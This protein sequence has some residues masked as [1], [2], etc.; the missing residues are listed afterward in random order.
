MRRAALQPAPRRWILPFP[1]PPSAEIAEE[2]THAEAVS[3]ETESGGWLYRVCED[4]NAM[5]LGHADTAVERLVL[6][7][8][9]DGHW[10]ARLSED[11]FADNAMLREAEIPASIGEIPET[12]FPN[13][14]S[15]EIRAYNGTAAMALAKKRG[16][17]FENRSEFDFFDDIVDLSEMKR[18]QWSLSGTTLTL[19][20]PYA[21]LAAEG[22]KLYL[23]A[24]DEYRSGLPV[25]LESV[26]LD[27]DGATA[28]VSA[29]N[30]MDAVN[31]YHVENEQLYVDYDNIVILSEG[32]ELDRDK[33]KSTARST[34]VVT[35]R[36]I[37]L[38]PFKINLEIAKGVTLSGS[39][40][41]TWDKATV[42]VDY[43]ARKLNSL[44]I[45][46]VDTY[47]CEL[48]L[49]SETMVEDETTWAEDRLA[50]KTS[51]E[52]RYTEKRAVKQMPK[53]NLPGRRKYIANVPLFSGAVVGVYASIYV[54]YSIEG[55]VTVGFEAKDTRTIN[56][57]NGKLSVSGPWPKLTD[58]YSISA[59][60][61]GKAGV[62]AD[63]DLR[64]G[65]SLGK[66]DVSV[67]IG[68][69]EIQLM[70]EVGCTAI[71]GTDFDPPCFDI[72]A[73][74]NL[75]GTARL[76]LVK[77]GWSKEFA[78][79]EIRD[80][81]Y[82][83]DGE[84]ISKPYTGYVEGEFMNYTMPLFDGKKLH[85]EGSEQK[86]TEFCFRNETPEYTA[87]FHYFYDG[88]SKKVTVVENDTFD[89]PEMSA[90]E[91]YEFVGWYTD[92]LFQN[93]WDSSEPATK[94]IELYA[95][96]KR[97]ADKQEDDP[98][99]G[100]KDPEDDPDDPDG[101]DD[102]APDNPDEEYTIMYSHSPDRVFEVLPDYGPLKSVSVTGV[103]GN[104]THITIPETVPILFHWVLN[105]TYAWRDVPVT[106]I[107]K[108]RFDDYVNGSI[109]SYYHQNLESIDL[110]EVTV[111]YEDAFSGLR[112]LKHVYS[113]QLDSLGQ[114]AFYNC[115]SLESITINGGY[116]GTKIGPEAFSG[117]T[118]LKSVT[119]LGKLNSVG[120]TAF[121]ECGNLESFNYNYKTST[122]EFD[123][124]VFYNCA[125]L[126]SFTFPESQTIIPGGMF[127]GCASLTEV[128]FP[129]GLKTI[130]ERAFSWSGII[131]ADLPD[132]ITSI[133]SWTFEHTEN[134]EYVHLP[135]SLERGSFDLRFE[136]SK[137]K[138][139]SIPSG[140]TDIGEYAFG[141]CK[142]LTRVELP[143]GIKSIGRY[144][145]GGC[146]SLEYINLPASLE[147]IADDGL[148]DCRSLKEIE[149]PAG[150]KRIGKSGIGMCESLTSI[151]LPD[152]L[153]EIAGNAF[154]YC[155]KLKS[156][157]IPD[158]AEV[159]GEISFDACD[160]LE[161][162]H[163][164]PSIEYY[165]VDV[166]DPS[167]QDDEYEYVNYY[168]PYGAGPEVKRYY[169]EVGDY[170][171]RRY[172][173][174]DRYMY[175]K[176]W[177][178]QRAFWANSLESVNLPDGIP[179]IPREA[180]QYTNLTTITIP[181]TVEEL[182]YRAFSGCE[183]L[184]SVSLPE[185]LKIV[186]QY[187][188][189]MCPSLEY[190]NIPESLEAVGQ[191]ACLLA[192]GDVVVP[193]NLKILEW[194]NFELRDLNS[195]TVWDSVTSI[196]SSAFYS[197][198]YNGYISYRFNESNP[199]ETVYVESMD[200]FV[201]QWFRENKPNAFLALI[202][203][204]NVQVSF[205]LKGG[206]GEVSSVSLP[207]GGRIDQP[208]D[209]THDQYDFLGWFSNR[210]CTE[211][212]DFD[213]RLTGNVTLY[214]GWG[215]IDSN[216][217]YVTDGGK[218]IVTNYKGKI[219]NLTMPDKLDGLTV[220]GLAEGAIPDF[221]QSL[222][223][224]STVTDVAPG[225]FRFAYSLSEIKLLG[226]NGRIRTNG[227][228][229][230][231]D[232]TLL[233]YPPRRAGSAYT[234]PNGTEEIAS[235]AMQ[236][237]SKLTQLTLPAS[238]KRID[239][240]A[241]CE[242]EQL[243]R[244]TFNADPESI[245]AGNFASHAGAP[246]LYGP[247]DAPTLVSYADANRLSYNIYL[248]GLMVD[249]ELVNVLP[250]RAGVRFD[251]PTLEE[252][253][254]RGFV[255]WTTDAEGENPWDGGEMP[256]HHLRLYAKWDNDFEYEITEDYGSIRYAKLTRY[257]G[258]K[259]ETRIPEYIDG[260]YV[261][262][263]DGDCFTGTSVKALIG[264]GGSN[265]ESFAKYHGLE[266][267]PI[268][269]TVHFDCAGG[270]PLDDVYLPALTSLTNRD[271]VPTPTREGWDFLMWSDE[272]DRD[273]LAYYLYVEDEDD[274]ITL[275]ARWQP[276]SYWDEELEDTVT[277]DTPPEIPFSFKAT[278][279]GLAITGYTGDDF[280]ATVPETIN[281]LPVVAIAAGAFEGSTALYSLTL[282]EG[283][284]RVG[285]RAF[286]DSRI[287]DVDM[288]G[289]ETIEAYAFYN[290]DSLT[291][292]G[293]PKVSEIGE[294][295]F[296][297]CDA[298]TRI[299]LPE[300]LEALD[301]G[302]FMDCDWL[303][304]IELP[305]ALERVE[306]SVFAEC[307]QLKRVTLGASVDEIADNAFNGC[308]ALAA[309]EVD[310]GNMYYS[311]SDGVLFNKAGNTLLRYPAGK[312]DASYTVPE[313]VTMIAAGAM[314]NSRLE[315][316]TLGSDVL[317][318]GAG[319]LQN[320]KA[321]KELN[322]NDG[323]EK[324]G[325]NAFSGC[326]ALKAVD[327]PD[328]VAV[329]RDSAFNPS[330][331]TEIS[332][333]GDTD[334]ADSALP[335]NGA[336]TVYGAKD[337]GAESVAEQRGIRFVDETTVQVTGISLPGKLT[338]EVGEVYALEAALTPADTTE[339]DI[340]W[341]TSDNAVVRVTDE[342]QITARSVGT[343]IVTAY[344]LNG[345]SAQCVVTVEP[346]AEPLSYEDID[347]SEADFR[348]PAFIDSIG[349]EAFMGIEAEFVFI[350]AGCRSIGERAFANCPNLR[351][352][353]F[354]D[355]DGV[356]AAKSFLEGSGRAVVYAKPGT[357]MANWK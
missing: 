259:T 171:Y 316:L 347:P 356:T 257:H 17:A 96:W 252:E 67:T 18:A 40:Q 321:L 178:A 92:L 344:A 35:G 319:T 209:P 234:V 320:S 293:M 59:A 8:S 199:D 126:K 337:S 290:R 165:Y 81:D 310:A 82:S 51:G 148:W 220:V 330:G 151:T 26:S 108:L 116:W 247:I 253:E 23:P 218:A 251:P 121:S 64:L 105:D 345:A 100:E 246:D 237:A 131:R 63:L 73:A 44:Q 338:L 351:V 296:A 276:I 354:E 169:K 84:D 130:E 184:F 331:L 46:L 159:Y 109:V 174:G 153:V 118:S 167:T 273:H 147:T 301:E 275:Y 7:K 270:V 135:A 76:G 142:Y 228:A 265:A 32:V 68:E 269:H 38:A 357:A 21:L 155:E 66:V 195:L 103:K 268:L 15:L 62:G 48:S 34:A 239:A 282:P 213:T 222:T 157:Y 243:S 120:F 191:G 238:L 349:D 298:L 158:N 274:E 101:P 308:A 29:I 107:T 39:V 187:V 117:C 152:G 196:A 22:K 77:T 156:L 307:K 272:P 306:G 311:S 281:G 288:P 203:A 79:K 20:M 70:L 45:D 249:D 341:T 16:F 31:S 30:F 198:Y 291:E 264:E 186:G 258:V 313:G 227:G 267:I 145:F 25:A 261:L 127:N 106:S 161:S 146:E 342:G 245:G 193:K 163:F 327:I 317:A 52:S 192:K 168:G 207:Y 141:N 214:A 325:E 86:W 53:Q 41:V 309:I 244:V 355:G 69:I 219:K 140:F 136:A 297:D 279:G 122:P 104:P 78:S 285:E 230:F 352:V 225:A 315:S 56:Y 322:L 58:N 201:A 271:K 172:D 250:M 323:L 12:A 173:R 224:P 232:N 132:G 299:T 14:A 339:T 19:G 33:L 189:D 80:S 6:P 200:G 304:E 287:A 278:D 180:F 334:V 231:S 50:E 47:N 61:S 42:T 102:P 205:D 204:G 326:L 255:G 94:D 260:A 74:V 1:P 185:G 277:L 240:F 348:L 88:L 112:G 27:A 144:A 9:V 166:N 115:T 83:P 346:A 43:S 119:V 110:G 179:E 210:D 223:L 254:T 177:L 5:L 98:G 57:S 235:Y 343:A 242:S 248:I 329:I 125:K 336:L 190:M 123:S 256:T 4:G 60:V 262:S 113:K 97:E 28:R 72:E 2:P 340:T 295:A 85:W 149:L 284:K 139:I 37:R 302:A 91:G 87:T 128:N 350:P 289:V 324:I 13:S 89:P 183:R 134:L 181:D 90:R 292:V 241:I 95:K 24:N 206:M 221:V 236:Y 55:E 75:T 93:E 233:F 182:G 314:K 328:S 160:A 229:L 65:F 188:F 280:D 333:P 283:V 353:Y 164:P 212:W 36:D 263:I 150:L 176:A 154:T 217:E 71:Y 170:T 162:V 294:Y 303:Q 226:N 211:L 3:D 197:K 318:V 312:T 332:I 137:I 10:V 133:G 305:D 266:F 215:T 194:K 143:E 286:A 99:D 216:F 208:A 124:G 300:G 114:K 175:A 54:D 49:H 138:E 129:S 11:A 335:Y 202:N 111:I